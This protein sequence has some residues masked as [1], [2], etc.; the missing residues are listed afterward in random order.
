MYKRQIYGRPGRISK[1]ENVPTSG[2]INPDTNMFLSPGEIAQMFQDIGA[3]KADR[4]L[5]YCGGGIAASATAML[6]FMLGYENVGLY[7][8]SMSE[9]ANDESLPMETGQ[10]IRENSFSNMLSVVHTQSV[11]QRRN[12]APL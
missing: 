12:G 11:T 2:L 7:D 9:W 6:L 3:D 1:S 8:N 5:T 10:H 4:V